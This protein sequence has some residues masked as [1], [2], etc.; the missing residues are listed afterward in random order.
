MHTPRKSRCPLENIPEWWTLC[1]TIM[2]VLL[3]PLVLFFCSGCLAPYSSETETTPDV[4][5]DVWKAH[6]ELTDELAA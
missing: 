1:D 4:A 6:P 2:L 3:G 5:V